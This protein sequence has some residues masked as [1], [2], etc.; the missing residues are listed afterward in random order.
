VSLIVSWLL[1]PIFLG[2]VSIGCGLVLQRASGLSLGPLTAPAGLAVVIVVAQ[3]AAMSDATAELAVPVVLLLA[4]WGL[5]GAARGGPALRLGGWPLATAVVVY[6]FF[7]LP[8]FASGDATWAGYIRLDDTATWLAM[9]DRVLD[10]GR[11]LSGLP[12]STYEV[13]LESYI[14][15]GYPIGAFL[16]LALARELTGQDPAWLFQPFQAFLAAMLA[17]ALYD[18]C[19]PL[20]RSRRWRAGAAV[21]ASQPALLYAYTLWGGL[22][23]IA[24]AAL[25]AAVAAL[26]VRAVDAGPRPGRPLGTRPLLAPAMAGAATL[27]VGSV[28]AA[29]WL[30]APLLVAAFMWRRRLGARA[31]LMGA[32]Q[33]SALTLAFSLPT[34]LSAK[35]FLSPGGREVLTSDRELGNL[36]EPLDRLQLFGVWPVGDFRLEPSDTTV[37]YA[38]IAVV[39]AAACVGFVVA[40]SRRAAGP[41]TYLSAAALG[42]LVIAAFGSPWVDAKAL[43]IASPAFLL[44][45][46]LGTASW[47]RRMRA[48]G[49]LAAAAITLG[50]VWSN[51][52][53]YREVTLA[54][55]DRFEEL[56]RIGERHAGEGP[57]L[58]TEYEPY[59]VRHFLR[60]LDPEGASEFRRR[61]VALRDGSSLDKLEFADL[62]EFRL[63]SLL[64]YRTLVL[65]RSPLASRPPSI[66]RLVFEGDFYEVWQ[67]PPPPLGVVEHHSLGTKLEPGAVPDCREVRRLA[68][69]AGP[70]GRLAAVVRPPATVVK[71]PAT[72]HPVGWRTIERD[73]RLLVPARAG[74]LKTVVELRARGRYGIWLGGA[75]RRSLEVFVDGRRLYSRRHRLSHAEQYEP[76]GVAQLDRGR[77]RIELR[78]GKA[79]VHPGSDGQ[80]F[81]IGPL[82]LGRAT[83]A[84]DV[85]YVD[86]SDARSLCAK[87][88]DWI[89]AL[90]S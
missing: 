72:D 43:A 73:D 53:A 38:L 88:L 15:D 90:R 25:I 61:Q 16:P 89:E 1:L 39:L 37:T 44:M 12:P 40:V 57:A 36:V 81:P 45:A 7:A 20:I 10:H 6:G 8:T 86:S 41:L 68:G 64:V 42:C 26:L 59:G 52:V 21:V 80:A 71:L 48:S 31:S 62:D 69:I 32:G 54:P 9:T 3:A 14:G 19:E 34:L 63:G 33:L 66:Y 51:A 47:R 84:S 17:L 79:D 24:A 87:R 13:T 65:R 4:A 29:A 50:V 60:R 23:E 5:I 56:E 58:M 11:D 83:A 27:A 82:V 55:R 78:Y 74:S 49:V 28:A 77:H 30:A 18:L 22:K 2:A 76:L 70:G 75:Y 85:T 35:A 46:M 67:R